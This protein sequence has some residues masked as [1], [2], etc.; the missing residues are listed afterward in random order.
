MAETQ[1][2]TGSATLFAIN[3]GESNVWNQIQSKD[4]ILD[5]MLLHILLW[6]LVRSSTMS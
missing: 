2:K 6:Q 3:S 1:V 4:S 5:D